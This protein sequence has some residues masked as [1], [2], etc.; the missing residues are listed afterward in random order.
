M[1]DRHNARLEPVLDWAANAIGRG[2]R[3]TNVASL[4]DA[5][6]PWRLRIEHRGEASAAVLRVGDMGNRQELATEAAALVFAE[7]HKLAAPRLIAAALDGEAAGA[8]AVLSTV[9]DGSSK[10]PI[11]PSVARLRAFG[12]AA[13]R[14]H[15]IPITPQPDLP[16][17]TRPI[18]HDNFAAERRSRGSSP[19]LDAAEQRVNARP[20]PQDRTVFVHG[21]LWQGNTL[22][23]GEAC[24]GLID[25]DSAGAG[26]DGVDLGSV[27]LDAAIM[28]GLPAA[29]QALA[30][31]QRATGREAAG[32]AYWDIV[33]ALSTP[34]DIAQW[35]PAIHGQGRTD[36]DLPTVHHRREAFLRAALDQLD[37][38]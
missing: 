2:A 10:I 12:A 22:W 37:R 7:G 4:R 18:P 1:G 34:T 24:V 8:V 28:F 3:I 13:G 25:W 23:V 5:T 6:G 29:A 38:E 11:T 15:A 26:H 19:L 31:W 16:R 21:D 14:L 20:M 17:R 32:L 27:R 30:G 9:L 36:L 35:L 33:A